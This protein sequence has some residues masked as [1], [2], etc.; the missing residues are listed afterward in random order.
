MLRTRGPEDDE[1]IE[2]AAA[3]ARL[4]EF[5]WANP[6]PALVARGH[7]GGAL[8]GWQVGSVE[9][10]RRAADAGCDLIVARGWRPA[11]TSVARSCRCSM[12]CW[13]LSAYRC[14]RP[15]ASRPVGPWPPCW[16]PGR[17]RAHRHPVPGHRGVWRPSR[18]HRGAPGRGHRRDRADRGVRCGVAGRP[19]PRT[20][21]CGR[22]HPSPVRADGRVQGWCAGVA[23]V[24]PDRT[25]GSPGMWPPWRS[26]PGKASARSP[27][28]RPPC[29]SWRA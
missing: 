26:T 12:G 23:M 5:F 13:P 10:A 29:R 19:T 8:A 4:V 25:S 22:R 27:T 6:N 17:G 20:G 14:W 2:L 16:W 9:E 21:G 1:Q 15:A 24:Q 18:L 3:H 11:V 7:A 28:R